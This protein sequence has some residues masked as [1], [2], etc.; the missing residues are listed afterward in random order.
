M[1]YKMT[2]A[3]SVIAKVIAD[4]NLEEKDIRIT[5]ISQW[6][7][8]AM[9]K[10]G[11]VTQLDHKVVVLPLKDYQVKL[12]CDLQKLDSVAY[13]HCDCG[14]WV[15][16]KKATGSFSIHGAEHDHGHHCEMLFKDTTLLP[17]VKAMFGIDKD[18]E[19]LEKLHDD[20][21]LGSTIGALINSSTLCTTNGK[22]DHHHIGTNFSFRPQYDIK[23][24]YLFGNMRDGFVKL[25]YFAIYTDDEGMPLIPDMISYQEAIYWYVTVKLMYP[26]FLA[27]KLNQGVYTDMRNSWNFYCK[28]AY[29]EAMMPNTDEMDNI[30]NTWNTLIP[31]MTEHSTFYS[32]TGDRQEVYNMNR[33]GGFIWQ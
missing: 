28:Q 12:P 24:G 1:I 31:E 16:M 14:G 5:D 6:I 2:T 21:N 33:P 4:L 7:G 30:K 15:P 20:K 25:S 29:A 19:A 13:S 11:A 26:Q 27:G 17:V 23:P 32:T 22:I 3:K 10:I 8:E 18:E 9:E